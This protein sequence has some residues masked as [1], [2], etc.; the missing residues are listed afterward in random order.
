MNKDTYD[1]SPHCSA[2]GLATGSILVTICPGTRSV[3]ATIGANLPI[4]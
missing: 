3:D 1:Q 2:S 4:G